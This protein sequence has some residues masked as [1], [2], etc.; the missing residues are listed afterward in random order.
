M[1]KVLA[2][3]SHVVRGH[4]GLDATVP[5]LQWLGHEVWALASEVMSHVG[6]FVYTASYVDHLKA[7]RKPE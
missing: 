1:A 5:A 7:N 4:V 3:S 6:D 2:I